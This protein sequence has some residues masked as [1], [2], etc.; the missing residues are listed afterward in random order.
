MTVNGDHAVGQLVEQLTIGFDTL[1]SEYRILYDR[2]RELENKLAWAKQQY[3]DLLKRFTPDIALQ[4]HKVFVQSLEEVERHGQGGPLDWLDALAQSD[5]G[6]RRTGAYIIRQAERARDQLKYQRPLQSPLKEADGVKI[7]N[8]RTDRASERI[9]K[10]ESLRQAASAAG[11]ERDFTTPG[12]PGNL[13]CPFG[14]PSLRGRSTSGRGGMGTPSRSQSRILPHAMRSK[15]SSFNDPIRAEICG[16]EPP[17]SP[18]PS[19]SGSAAPVCPIRFMDDHTPEDIAKY[20][21]NHKHELP[22]SHEV[23]IKRFQS[24]AESIR[25]LDAKYGNLVNMIQGLGEKHQPMLKETP[26]DEDED[27]FVETE[28]NSRVANWAK[29]VSTSAQAGGEASP[30]P[31]HPLSEEEERQPHFDRPMKEIRVGESPSRPWGITVPA[32]YNK[33]PSVA[34][35]GVVTASP[36]QESPPAPPVPP[37][38]EAKKP[39]KCP[40]DHTKLR[41]GPPGNLKVEDTGPNREPEQKTLQPDVQ[42]IQASQPPPIRGPNIIKPE[43]QSPNSP[44][45]VFT[46]PVFIGYSMEQAVALLQQTGLGGKTS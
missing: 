38:A 24:N 19:V 29:A 26:A 2:H 13:G 44:Q 5:D 15:R 11:L 17:Q 36:V 22:R 21:E 45:M 23:C 30:D 34:T 20:F 9:S 33:P 16:F 12:T 7:W 1:S 27:A 32:A 14:T 25:Q 43:S 10:L 4:D 3:L 18:E 31:D 46:G 8:G 35:D 42:T 28:S 40:F 41:G 6:D 39:G 37:V